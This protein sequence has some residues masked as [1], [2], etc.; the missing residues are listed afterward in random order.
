MAIQRLRDVPR[1]SLVG[2]F[3]CSPSRYTD[4]AHG[5]PA[6]VEKT[7]AA[8][9]TFRRLPRGAWD[10]DKREWQV[11]PTMVSAA[12]NL[13]SR[14][15]CELDGDERAEAPEQCN[16]SSVKYVCDTAEEAI[17]LYFHSLATRDA[18]ETF[19]KEM[20]A[21]VDTQALAGGI[22]VPEYLAVTHSN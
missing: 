17:A 19:R 6:L 16:L 13:E 14:K 22:P 20:L 12:T 1:E 2:K 3:I 21:K 5:W 4:Q 18:I 7:T 9:L 11:R 8:R 10:A 15:S